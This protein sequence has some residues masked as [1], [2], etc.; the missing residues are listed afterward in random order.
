LFLM[1][2]GLFVN[3]VLPAF[4]V[5]EPLS[6]LPLTAAIAIS[7]SLLTARTFRGRRKVLPTLQIPDYTK[8]EWGIVAVGAL[9]PILS[10]GGAISLNNHGSNLLTLLS[11]ALTCIYGLVIVWPKSQTTHRAYPAALFFMA[12]AVLLATSLRGWNITGHDIMQEYQVFSL[13]NQHGLWS[14]NFLQDAYN[15]CLSITILPTML[16][17]LTGLTDIYVY[18]FLYQLLFALVPVI[19][20]FTTSRFLPKKIA[21]MSAFAFISFPTFITDMAM[22]GR[23]EI[24]LVFFALF[25]MTLFHSQLRRQARSI[26]VLLLG[27]GMI[28][29]HYSTA[30]VA[31]G[32]ILTAKVFE[33]VFLR[34]DQWRQRRS[35]TRLVSV[36][37]SWATAIIMLLSIYAWNS[38]I[39]N[40]GQNIAKTL[41]GIV[42]NLPNIIS[43]TNKSAESGYSLFA[44]RLSDDQIFRQYS[45]TVTQ[46][47]DLSAAAYYPATVTNHYPL[48]RAE[49]SV[50]PTTATGRV[51]GA[52]GS[53]LYGLYDTIR[54]VYAQLIQLAILLGLAI[55]TFRPPKALTKLPRQYLM[56]GFASLAM[57][58]LQV[59]LPSSVVN[60]GLL[61]LLQQCLLFLT[62]AIIIA[63]C[64]GLGWLRLPWDWRIRLTAGLLVG[65]FAVNS[66]LIPAITGGY[67]PTLTTANSGFYYDGYYTHTEEVA[68]YQWLRANT[69]KGSIVNADEFARRAMI[70]YSGIYARPSLA[71]AAIASDAYVYLSYGNTTTGRVPFYYDGTLL[72]MDPPT[73]FLDDTKNLVYSNGSVEIYK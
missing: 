34:L 12:L 45:G 21:L 31:M 40:T 73:Q 54:S 20:Y 15:A 24:A 9:L 7:L 58:A 22:L 41:G 65:F 11:L 30:Y 29:S 61:R 64:V 44:T 38:Q 55:L 68:G 1:A 49:Q 23:Q 71:P 14:M 4:G 57:V 37:L 50:A 16:T 42:I 43:Q 63:F 62:P 13:T 67:K 28:W 26:L 36:P 53:V 18:K 17:R 33:V 10:A 47:R 2:I 6:K 19:L 56:L 60:Y 39:T 70:T 25:L 35:N 72:Y 52:A 3:T 59:L 5:A 8:R 27:L 46:S 69:P 66:G 32:V 48:T 51:L